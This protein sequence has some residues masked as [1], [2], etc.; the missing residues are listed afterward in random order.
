MDFSLFFFK[1]YWDIVG[2]NVWRLVKDAFSNG[3]FDKSLA[4]TLS[5][6]EITLPQ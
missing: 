4:E 6:K 3:S 5:L 1:S 2:N